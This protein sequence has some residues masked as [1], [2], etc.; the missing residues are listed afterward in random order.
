MKYVL[1]LTDFSDIAR[2]AIIYALNMLKN[3]HLYYKLVNTYDLEFSGSPYVMQVKDELAEE[4]IKGLNNELQLIHRLFPGVRVELASR[5]GSLIEVIQEEVKDYN[6]DLIVLGNKGESAIEHFLLGSNAYEIIKRINKPLLVVPK[7]A[8]FIKPE[9]IVFATDLNDFKSD[10][11][12]RPVRDI[13]MYFNAQLL[14]IHVLE[15]SDKDRFEAENKILSHFPDIKSAFYYLQGDNVAKRICDFVDEQG[16]GMVIMI[17]HNKSFF[18]RI[19]YTSTT[20][21]MILHPKHTLV[22]LHDEVCED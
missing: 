8:H 7:G 19:I 20:K 11:V 18:E 21:Q 13:V 12:I 3:E 1:L 22:V 5:F 17:R 15:E 6:P 9:K 14:F 2:N 4:S 16:A 10:D